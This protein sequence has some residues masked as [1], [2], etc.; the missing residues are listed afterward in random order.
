MD[1]FRR[2]RTVAQTMSERY[3]PIGKIGEGTYG[4]VYKARVAEAAGVG[5]GAARPPPL[6]GHGDGSSGGC[7]DG[8]CLVAVK[9]FKCFKSG[10]GISPTAVRE[11]KLLRELR[12]PAIVSLVDVLLDTTVAHPLLPA[13]DTKA[14]GGSSGMPV[15]ERSLYLV[16]EYADHD[17]LDMIRFHHNHPALPM[18]TG[19]IKS[20]LYQILSGLAYLHKNWILHRDLKPSN[21]LVTGGDRPPASRG[22][23]KIADFGLARLFQSPLRP[24]PDVDAV[25]VTIWYRAPELLLGARHYTAAVDMWAVGCIFAELCA[26]KP[27][28]QGSE[29]ER[30]P[31]DRAPFQADQLDKIFRLLGKPSPTTWPGVT[32]LPHWTDV[33]GWVGYPNRLAS[34]LPG[35]LKAGGA[36][37]DLLARLLVYNPEQR[38]SAE[39]A[40]AHPYFRVRC[41][42]LR[43][44]LHALLA[45]ARTKLLSIPFSARYSQTFCHAFPPSCDMPSPAA[46]PYCILRCATTRRSLCPDPTR[47]RMTWT[48]TPPGLSLRWMRQR[49]LAG[50]P[51][52]WL[53]RQGRRLR[54]PRRGGCLCLSTGRRTRPSGFGAD[55]RGL[56]EEA[57]AEDMLQPFSSTVH[58]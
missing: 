36:G 54:R 17:L 51:R 33:R 30:A 9:K 44:A 32:S 16:F 39:E 2:G 42:G 56:W 13:K 45:E 10:D 12:H 22:V 48:R 18:P 47:L 11:I 7:G 52:R 40:L 58:T 4:L 50:L 43:A 53:V 29:R 28:F 6:S 37:H 23:I 15:E 38:I 57:S 27:L 46:P 14:G 8:D 5:G 26:S 35:R 24:L 49:I 41:G 31:D 20:L 3:V 1:A 34:M 19:T 55:W 25:V 21:I